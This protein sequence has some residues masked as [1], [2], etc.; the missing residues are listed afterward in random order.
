MMVEQT[1]TAANHTTGSDRH[2]ALMQRAVS[3]IHNQYNTRLTLNDLAGMSI[4]Q[5][6]T[7]VGYDDLFY[8]MRVF[9][10]SVG[11]PPGRFARPQLCS[12]SPCG[13]GQG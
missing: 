1:Y 9:R 5:V 4:K 3:L 6:A 12:L 8:F 7:T 13:R 10:K 11:I 2:H